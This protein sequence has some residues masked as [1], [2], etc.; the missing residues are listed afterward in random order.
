MKKLSYSLLTFLII[1][2]LFSGVAGASSSYDVEIN[3]YRGDYEYNLGQNI[4]FVIENHSNEDRFSLVSPEKLVKGEWIPLDVYPFPSSLPPGTKE[5]VVFFS[6][7]GGDLTQAGTYRL[8]ID[9]E[10]QGYFYSDTFTLE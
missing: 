4:Y 6:G 7:N 10:G 5:D 2:S 3:A 9:V 8:K 1:L